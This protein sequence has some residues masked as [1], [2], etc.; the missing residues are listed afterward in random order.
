MVKIGLALSCYPQT[1]STWSYVP[2]LGLGYLASYTKLHAGNVEFVVERHPED[3]IQHNPDFVGLTFV[4]FNYSLAVR[5]ARKIKDALGCPVICGGP[6]V[7]T[8]PEVLDPA[9]DLAVLGEGEATF[10]ELVRLWNDRKAF[11]P[12]DLRSIPGLLFHNEDGQ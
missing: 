10:A 1:D 6:H 4:I 9:F 2:P 11:R 5:Q 7:S 12:E 8:L 3:L